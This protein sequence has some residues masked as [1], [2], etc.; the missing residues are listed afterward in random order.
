MA[1]KVLMLGPSLD[2]R[3]GMATFAR[4]VLNATDTDESDGISIAYYPTVAQGSKLNKLLFSARSYLGFYKAI[5][6]ADI[7]HLNFSLGA[8]LPRKVAFARKAKACGKK[9]VLHSHSSELENAINDARP[10]VRRQVIPFLLMAD[11]VI[12]LTDYWKETISSLG[13]EK[14]RIHVVPNGVE[15]PM[16]NNDTVQRGLND[17]RVPNVLYLGRLEQDKGVEDLL[18]AVSLIQL[19]DIHIK[20]VL[21][22]SGDSKYVEFLKSKARDLFLDVTFPGWIDGKEKTQTLLNADVFVLPSHREVLPISLLEA[23]ASGV[24]SIATRVG[25]VPEVMEDGINGL[26]CD[27]GDCESL[28]IALQRM[29]TDLA[30]RRKCANAAFSTVETRYSIES[31]MASL[32][33]TYEKV[34]IDGK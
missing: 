16:A 32:H 6:A 20:L 3:G 14:T 33:K 17:E 29:C 24:A 13:I 21:A 8:S 9:V 25:A 22:G 31:M 26:L 15:I 27:A 5:E 11:A 12:V 34:L 28:A 4:T 18:D 2:S 19:S 30:L 10:V 1:V 23:M 7:V